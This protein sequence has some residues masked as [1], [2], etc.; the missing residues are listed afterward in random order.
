MAGWQDAPVVGGSGWQSAPTVDPNAN[1]AI[2]NMVAGRPQI[3]RN[4]LKQFAA[5][6]VEGL[7]GWRGDLQEA[8]GGGNPQ[9]TPEERRVQ[10]QVMAMSPEP[11]LFGGY[12][13]SRELNSKIGLPTSAPEG[14][15]YMRTIGNF[16]S[17]AALPGSLLQRGLRVLA[18]AGASESAARIPGVH[19][20]PLEPIVRF[21]AAL[22][23]GIGGELAALKMS[24][25]KTAPPPTTLGAA[26]ARGPGTS[27]TYSPRSSTAAAAKSTAS[28][29]RRSGGIDEADKAA[30]QY[31]DAG[32]TPRTFQVGGVPTER[33]LQYLARAPGKTGTAVEQAL[34]QEIAQQ[35]GEIKQSFRNATGAGPRAQLQ[36]TI[37]DRFAA[38]GPQYDAT[39]DAPGV[40]NE[41]LEKAIEP[42]L[43]WLEK[44]GIGE[45][46]TKRAAAIAA[47]RKVDF[48]S[49]STARQT[50]YI[51]RGVK[52]AI[53]NAN[54]EGMGAEQVAGLRNLRNELVGHL[55]DAAPGYKALNDEWR[56]NALAGE[57][58]GGP[59]EAGFASKFFGMGA[60]A[61]RDA[62]LA[63]EFKKAP[64][65]AQKAML[66]SIQNQAEL[67]ISKVAR[68]DGSGATRN[69]AAPFMSQEIVDRLRAVM[70][71]KAE[72]L[73]R[74]LLAQNKR[75]RA[76]S[77]VQPRGGSD[78]QPLAMEGADA[79]AQA[80]TFMRK[81]ITSIAEAAIANPL[82]E[83]FRN[84]QGVGLLEP[85]TPQYR[86]LVLQELAR[87]DA[88]RSAIA[89]GG[90][91]GTTRSQAGNASRQP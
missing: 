7:A 89:G 67:N 22:A 10:Q 21:G 66:T 8:L 86:A 24:P 78:T 13:T 28:L 49:L 54:V 40:N 14:G 43:G 69:V 83:N 23:G 68:P 62:D 37:D 64:P 52:D 70:G 75:Y 90:L 33:R 58:L 18:P 20:S 30:Q 71:E 1:N 46:I 5:G 87:I 85:W 2:A 32:I 59:G 17:G 48:D 65:E 45:K 16:A 19:G 57:A 12:P 81:P 36:Q 63:A 61:Y 42:T 79:M 44:T 47:G 3:D 38:L 82:Y 55:E 56:K 34:E 88:R 26:A 74:H 9:F 77:F 91:F 39:L 31:V 60:T 15:S 53:D 11:V 80:H 27:Y 6:G 50:Q 84:K 41:A 76:W 25:P 73:I 72:P 4:P 29:F 35:P 51:I